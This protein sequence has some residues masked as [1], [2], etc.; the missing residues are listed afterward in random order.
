MGLRGPPK[1][2]QPSP[3]AANPV[4]TQLRLELVNQDPG[5][6]NDK[7]VYDAGG[8]LIG[9]LMIR[10]SYYLGD[11][12]GG[13]L[14]SETPIRRRASGAGLTVHGVF[15]MASLGVAALM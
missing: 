14:F 12:F 1:F 8:Y 11:C 7:G 13:P 2:H 9:V 4:T 10:G 15:S 6:L 3:T 5:G